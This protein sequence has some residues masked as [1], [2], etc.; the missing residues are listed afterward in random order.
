[1]NGMIH[2]NAVAS[3]RVLVQCAP[4]QS[5]YRLANFDTIYKSRTFIIL[6]R[7]SF[8]ADSFLNTHQHALLLHFEFFV[9]HFFI[10]MWMLLYVFASLIFVYSANFGKYE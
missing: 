1:M 7:N 8:Y 9:N 6:N 5:V 10:H 2:I 4:L 3:E